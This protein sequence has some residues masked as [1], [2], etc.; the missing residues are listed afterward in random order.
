MQHVGYDLA[1]EQVREHSRHH[2][3]PASRPLPL[4]RRTAR[5]LRRIA[6]GLDGDQE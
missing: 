1:L 2:Q 3:L 5:A 4:R 6:A